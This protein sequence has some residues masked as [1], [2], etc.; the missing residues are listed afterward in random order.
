MTINPIGSE[1]SS[2]PTR[3]GPLSSRLKNVHVYATTPFDWGDITQVDLDGFASNLDFIVSNGVRVLVVGGGTGELEALS[4][5]ELI[6]IVKVA[7][8]VSE[9]K[10]LTIAGLPP[11]LSRAT[12]LLADYERLGIEVALSIPPFVRW[13]VPADLE[14]VA[15]YYETLSRLSSLALMPYN[16]QA[17]PAEFFS[18]LADIDTIIGIKDPCHD[19]LEFFRAIKALGERFVW[20]GNKRHD[21]GVVHL[22]YQMGMEGFTSGQGNYLPRPELEMHEAALRQDWSRIVSLQER[23]APLEII[24]SNNDDA[25]CVKAAMDIVGLVGGA[26]RP[27]R[28]DLPQAARNALRS[29]LEQVTS[30]SRPSTTRTEDDSPPYS[31]PEQA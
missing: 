7:I 16:V 5:D 2:M 19:P 23:V 12:R 4:D 13:R 18:R 8:S 15:A 9:G 10:V 20:I 27:P 3:H 24:R 29:V 17:W 22:R 26:V 11:N 31:Q 25:A 30:N 21:P 1:A 6:E 14:G 28:L